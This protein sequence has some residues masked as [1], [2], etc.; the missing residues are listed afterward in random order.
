[1]NS[2]LHAVCDGQRPLIQLLSEGQISDFGGATLMIEAFPKAQALLGDKG[3]DADWFREALADREVEACLPLKSNHKIHI[4]QDT[5]PYRQLYKIEIMFGRIKDWRPIHTGYDR[6]AH[7][8]MSAIA[9]AATII[10]WIN[11]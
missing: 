4:P 7:T 9:I 10:F 11:Q 5:V 3:Y 8:L 1:M 6:C 2:K